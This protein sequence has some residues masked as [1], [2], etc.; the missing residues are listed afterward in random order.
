MTTINSVS[1]PLVMS[2]AGP[3][4][5]PPSVLNQD[6]IAGVAAQVPDYMANLPGLLIEDISSTATGALVAIDQ[7]RV[8]AIASVTPY[9]ANPYILSQQGFM[10]GIPQGSPTNTSV[11]VVFS[12]PAGYVLP[13][14]FIVSDG[15]YQYRLLNGGTI[16]SGGATVPLYA[17]ATQNGS[18][19]VPAG[20]VTQK[21]TSLQTPYDT[22]ITVTNPLAGTAG[23]TS[24]ESVQSY[25]SRVM[26]ANQIAGQ[27]TPAYLRTLL[28]AVSGVSARLVS[29][30]PVPTGWEVICGGGDPYAVAGAIYAG[31]LDLSTIVGSSTSARNI[32]VTITDPPNT[33][34][35]TFVNPP[36]QVVT[37]SAV[38]NTTL[39]NFTAGAQVNQLAAPAIQNYINS[40]VVGQPINLLAMEAEFQKAVASVLSTD[41]LTTLTFTVTI[42][43]SA[44]TPVAGTSVIL[45]DPESYF[46]CSASGVTV[47]Q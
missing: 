39:P 6:L 28:E 30:L 19:S 34:N 14:G 37:V 20:T 27:G 4:A 44:A 24:G 23:N 45:S 8:D 12:G 10:L 2:S 31:V 38:W 33:Y 40:I 47:I 36:Q 1:V 17:V 26:Q 29:I 43:G 9:G 41:S 22:L 42:N 35:I 11:Y 25:R 21:I 5:T 32:T 18:W 16:Q 7:S 46:A 15:T 3:Q 13:A